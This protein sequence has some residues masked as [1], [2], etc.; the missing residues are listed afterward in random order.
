[1]ATERQSLDAIVGTPVGWGTTPTV[2]LLDDDPD[3]ASGDWATW[4]GSTNTMTLTVGF[5]TPT[6][7]PTTGAGVQEFRI[8]IRKSSSGSGTGTYTAELREGGSATTL[9]TLA[10][11][12][13]E[14]TLDPGEVVSL[15]WDA[16]NLGT[17]DG[18]AVE[19]YLQ[20]D[21][22]G[23]GPNERNID[24]DAIEWNV[25]YSVGFT[26]SADAITSSGALLDATGVL[27]LAYSADALAATAALGAVTPSWGLVF[28]A[29]AIAATASAGAVVSPFA[30]W[31]LD[32]NA[33]S[34]TVAATVG[35]AATY[36]GDTTDDMSVVG[37]SADELGLQI[38]ASTKYINTGV[39]PPTSA[40]TMCCWFLHDTITSTRKYVM[41]CHN[42]PT[43][44]RCYIS[45]QTEFLTG[46]LGSDSP[47][48]IQGSTTLS[49]GRWY[50]V[51]LVWDASNVYLYLDG[52]EEYSGARNGTICSL[53]IFALNAN[54][55]D[56]GPSTLWNAG[57]ADDV[58]IYNDALTAAQILAL[59]GREL[60]ADVLAASGALGDA[61]GV[62]GLAFS[63]DAL[64]ATGALLDATGA[65][66]G[67]GLTYSA[68][69]LAA[70]GA[71]GDATGLLGYAYTADALTATGA[72]LDAAGVLGL[73]FS[74]DVLASAGAIG[75]ATPSLGLVFSGDALAST[76]A[77]GDASGLVG[78][79]FSA[80][81]LAST[82]ALGTATPSLG[83]V[84]IADV[85]AAAGALLDAT[86]AL[87][88]GGFTY[89][90]D[91][92]AS[93]GA[94][95]DASGAVGGGAL[96]YSADALA[97]TCALGTVTPS[98]GLVF[99]ADAI[100]STASAGA[101]SP[102][103]G[104]AYSS[105]ALTATAA[106]GDATGVH[107]GLQLSF[108]AS[109][110]TAT[111]SLGDTTLH[112]GHYERPQE[113]TDAL[114]PAARGYWRTMSGDPYADG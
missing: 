109:A 52:Q 24:I 114:G 111:A 54:D 84:F 5:P 59:S 3:S 8:R 65:V 97:A 102:V 95:G 14:S 87:G 76:A 41:G 20:F 49:S 13:S 4:D 91:V 56:A 100:A 80:D 106:L 7:N 28:A 94:L 32:D 103:L 68:D 101:L 62:L 75:A 67:G 99:P 78:F 88:G 96:T 31:P 1:M 92:L 89:T 112:F 33:A 83:L 44:Q 77:I 53:S 63:A 108:I 50:H 74:A 69:A 64:A 57:R 113:M 43:T 6:G 105:D 47:T 70:T 12:V 110:L 23:G 39:A 51:A 85:I 72:L 37:R 66:G 46:G 18:S 34:T 107:G 104:L 55:N 61:T 21:S 29:D 15:T 26:F 2:A 9:E 17:A 36:V 79:T 60:S 71:I 11:G 82:G 10:S 35:S 16:S 45:A 90:A 38:D 27:G 42:T 86:G 81:A 25:D 93:V 48:T 58:R 30:I 22:G 98:L 40:G 73:A 19:L